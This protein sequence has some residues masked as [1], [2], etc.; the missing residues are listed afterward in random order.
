MS[1]SFAQPCRTASTG[2]M[3]RTSPSYQGL[4]TAT[5]PPVSSAHASSV[6]LGPVNC[7]YVTSFSKGMAATA[8]RDGS[9]P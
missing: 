6:A 3:V 8:A 7:G 1:T 9:T 4:N 5:L 2:R